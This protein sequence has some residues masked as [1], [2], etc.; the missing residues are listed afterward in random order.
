MYAKKMNDRSPLRVFER[1]IHGGL[2]PGNLGVV[3]SRPGMGKS[4]FLVGIALD[5]LMR[6]RRVF[7]VALEQT[8]NHVREYYDEIFADLVRTTHL[9]DAASIRVGVERSRLV[10]TYLGHSFSM[11]KFRDSLGTLR[12]HLQFEPAAVV[13]DGFDFGGDHYD[14]LSGMRDTARRAGFE[15]WMSARTFKKAPPPRPGE[16]PWPLARYADLVSVVVGL[17]PEGNRIRIRLLKDHDN[18][19]ISS[20]YLDLDPQTMLVVER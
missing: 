18:P 8:V 10:H 13:I 9:E 19:D 14:E 2:G 3:V 5:D 4:S 6:G 11:V 12:E 17:D 1:S 7:H 16:L 20:L 15:L